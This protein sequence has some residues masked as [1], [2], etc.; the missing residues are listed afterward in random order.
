MKKEQL[1]VETVD[2]ID[3][4]P[5]F[6]VVMTG[7]HSLEDKAIK[8]KWYGKHKKILITTFPSNFNE[9]HLNIYDIDQEKYML[10]S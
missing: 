7:E 1:E 8:Y 6:D 4:P 3:G 9:L 2:A 5:T 10:K